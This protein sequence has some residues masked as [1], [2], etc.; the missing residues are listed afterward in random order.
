MFCLIV[1][2]NFY[3]YISIIIFMFMNLILYVN[4]ICNDFENVKKL[5]NE[6]YCLKDG[7][8]KYISDYLKEK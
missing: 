8:F 2:I 6:K 5:I 4:Y 7:C 3:Y 1:F